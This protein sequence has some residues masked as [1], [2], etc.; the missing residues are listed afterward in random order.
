MRCPRVDLTEV[1]WRSRLPVSS[2]ARFAGLWSAN[3]PVVRINGARSWQDWGFP[4][5]VSRMT[6]QAGVR[7]LDAVA[8]RVMRFLVGSGVAAIYRI[9][10]IE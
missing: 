2:G 4:R 8:S 10:F 7:L 3:K 5:E 6:R 9:V 1:I